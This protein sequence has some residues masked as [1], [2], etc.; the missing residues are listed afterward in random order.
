MPQLFDTISFNVYWYRYNA[1]AT[2][3]VINKLLFNDDIK[4]D[5]RAKLYGTL[6]QSYNINYYVTG[7]ES[8]LINAEYAFNE[9]IKCFGD[10]KF[11]II[12]QY[13]YLQN[14]AISSKNEDKFLEYTE[15][16]LNLISDIYEN[17]DE[18]NN[19]INTYLYRSKKDKGYEFFIIR[20]LRYCNTLE[21]TE[22][23]REVANLLISNNKHFIEINITS[24]EDVDIQKDYAL[25]LYKYNNKEI[26]TEYLER[27]YYFMKD[28]SGT[29]NEMRILSLYLIEILMGNE[30][31]FA[32]ALKIIE[33]LLNISDGY[34]KAFNG[35]YDKDS[36]N[37][38]K[39]WA[40][41]V[42]DK[43]YM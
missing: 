3:E 39:E 38:K 31:Y 16:Y 21:I 41:K 6:G 42:R 37:D 30:Y 40:L 5:E 28:K 14:L 4:G 25:L 1:K 15:K 2:I 9:A 27:C 12:R 35:L 43:L 32:D 13:S 17:I 24:L 19:K 22:K 7:D 11:Q 23:S 33:D 18:L 8:D 36:I 34:K 20:L 29:F 26:D 10:V